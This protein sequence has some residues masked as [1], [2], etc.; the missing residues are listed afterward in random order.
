[1][2]DGRAEENMCVSYMRKVAHDK[3]TVLLQKIPAGVILV[4]KD[5]KVSDMNHFCANIL[6]EET[7]LIYE[8]SPGLAGIQLEDVC[9]FADLFRTVLT[10]G[11]EISEKQIR[12]GEKVWLLSIYNI[13]PNRLVF[14]ILQDL[15]EPFVRQEWMLEQ[16]QEVIRKYME[17]VQQ[18]ACLLGENAAYTDATL[19]AVM[20]SVSSKAQ[21]KTNQANHQKANHH[22]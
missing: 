19:R 16:T 22:E 1:M 10:T 18:V 5:L 4:D 11:K 17:T 14:G 13:Q 15:H 7:A 9:P 6:G 21:I 8:A 20:N 3:A 2:L 12:D